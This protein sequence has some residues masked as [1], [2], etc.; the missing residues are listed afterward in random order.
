MKINIL[1]SGLL[2]LGVAV[3]S[4]CNTEDPLTGTTQTLECDYFTQNRVLVDDPDVTI[5]YLITC[6][7]NVSGDITIMPG[8]TIAF[9]TDAGISVSETG[10]FKAEGTAALPITFTGQDGVKGSWRGVLIDSS[11]P[12][13]IFDHCVVE[14][15]GGIAHN[16]NGD[17]GAFV[18]W[19][20][21]RLSVT[22]SI[23]R[24]SAS[25]GIN[26]TYTGSTLELGGNTIT[27]NDGAPLYIDYTYVDVPTSSD[28]YL[29]NGTTRI[30]VNGNGATINGSQNKTWHK[31]DVDYQVTEATSVQV[32]ENAVLMIEPGTTIYFDA[33]CELQ[34]NDQ[35]ALSAQGTMTQPIS[36]KGAT[37][38]NGSWTGLRFEFTANTLNSLQ[39]VIIE[40]AGGPSAQGAVYMWASSKLTVQ[41]SEISKSGSCAFFAGGAGGANVNLAVNDVVF[42]NNTGADYCVD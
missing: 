29:G 10:S 6:D 23:I 20:Q 36:F 21:S 31:V 27:Q 12:K 14:H 32:R 41:N 38:A 7:M 19:A 26:G 17:R 42:T 39:Y 2:V 34:V 3:I 4:S 1:K 37:A 22:N 24:Q 30:L 28:S 33:G 13:N 11:D 35:A 5:D 18:V 8:V 40:N 9:A 16:S 25:H 15:A